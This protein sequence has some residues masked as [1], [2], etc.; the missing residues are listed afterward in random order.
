MIS[1]LKSHFRFFPFSIK[2]KIK[3]AYFCVIIK[4]VFRNN[5]LVQSLIKQATGTCLINR[6]V[7]A[8]VSS[9]LYSLTCLCRFIF[10]RKA[11]MKHRIS[12]FQ[13]KSIS[14]FR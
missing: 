7:F 12:R 10:S 2:I 4:H 11:Y 3:E 13:R 1:F 6:N 5:L 8:V 14:F 9:H